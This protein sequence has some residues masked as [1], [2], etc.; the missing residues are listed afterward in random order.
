MLTQLTLNAVANHRLLFSFLCIFCFRI[1]YAQQA[2][3]NSVTEE[4]EYTVKEVEIKAWWMPDAF[5]EEVAALT[6]KG[7]RYD[8][9]KI[10]SVQNIIK[11]ELLK[12]EA[13][14]A[15]TL[16]D[17]SISV[18]YISSDVC[19][20]S[21]P[22]GPREV[23]V[24][25]RPWY[26]RVD[27]LNIGN[28]RLPI[29]RTARPLFRKNIPAL[30]HSTTPVPGLF[31]DASYGWGVS[32]Q[33][34][35]RLIGK[36]NLSQ[37]NR[38]L[39]VL[40]HARKSLQHSY[41]GLDATLQYSHRF[42]SDS[43][44]SVN[45]L[46]LINA[47]EDP[48]LELKNRQFQTAIRGGIKGAFNHNF[49]HGYHAGIYW[50]YLKTNLAH[51]TN[52]AAYIS[53]NAYGMYALMDGRAGKG[54][55]RLAVWLDAAHPQHPTLNDHYQRLVSRLAYAVSLGN[56]HSQV[57]IETQAGFGYTWSEAPQYHQ[58]YAGNQPVPF[59]YEPVHSMR[60]TT[61]PAGPLMRSLGERTGS[62]GYNNHTGG[63]TF[64][65]L[66]LNLA[67]P[68]KAFSKP[69]I[70]DVLI[71]EEP[72]EITL[73][74]ALKSQAKTVENFIIE[75]LIE[76]KGY[77]NDEATEKHAARIVNRDIRPTL[78]FLA[79]KANVYSIK[80]VLLSDLAG[81]KDHHGHYATWWGA[82]LGLQLNIVVA[83]F[84][85]SYM[86]TFAP[87]SFN[88]RGNFFMRISVQN[89]Y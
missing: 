76:N 69:L 56:N 86:H 12:S 37:K 73:R 88:R 51:L 60:H 87:S 85:A 79:D 72:R 43:T 18:L 82:G 46:A 28:N 16:I 39:D 31:T 15:R 84:E 62:F 22:D 1:V 45:L 8:P 9:A 40:V 2:A 80:P 6:G 36:E 50:R 66:N 53:E 34:A 58:F 74:S 57:D 30:L 29:P 71:Q 47:S 49:L 23:R 10:N 38:M 14:I 5:A 41:Y 4:M 11:E 13:A 54:F 35:S 7:K 77:P 83:R 67:I 59:L 52:P 75:D 70:P 55:S 3:C 26:L 48:L 21:T 65:H 61:I 25:Y 68:V 32:L 44:L 20:I 42:R 89:F 19:D 17:G 33:T 81:M 63:Q 64:W 27:L 78:N 24:Q